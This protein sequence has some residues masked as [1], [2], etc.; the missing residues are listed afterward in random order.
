MKISLI[1]PIPIII[2]I[3]IEGLVNIKQATKGSYRTQ[4][5]L[6]CLVSESIATH[7]S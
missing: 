6:A 5:V 2:D 4:T 1:A 3:V 7:D